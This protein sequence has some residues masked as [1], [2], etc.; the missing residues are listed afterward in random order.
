[1]KR[2]LTILPLLLMLAACSSQADKP[3]ETPKQTK[4]SATHREE[5]A[6]K[7]QPPKRNAA[8]EKYLKTLADENFFMTSW[9]SSIVGYEIV[10]RTATIK[11]KDGTTRE[12]A[13]KIPNFV[14]A[15]VNSN[16]STYKDGL[17][18]VVVKTTRGKIICTSNDPTE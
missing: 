8:F 18:K 14:W 10:G 9:Y 11:V 4:Q 13:E 17:D 5:V 2:I 16:V 12:A 7:P 1:M 6:P 15:D 3:Q